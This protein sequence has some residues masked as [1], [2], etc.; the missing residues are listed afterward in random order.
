MTSAAV[1]KKLKQHFAVHG[2]LTFLLSDNEPC[3]KS[4]LFKEFA[5]TWD[6]KHATSSPNYHQSNGLTERA[7]RSAKHLLMK[8]GGDFYLDLYN[9]RNTPAAGNL[10]SPAQRLMS[11]RT[12]TRIPTTS[13]MLEPKIEKHVPLKLK[14]M[15]LQKKKHYDMNA[16][17][18]KPLQ[19][20]Q[21]VRL[22]TKRRYRERAIVMKEALRPRSYIVKTESGKEF[23]RNR[24]HFLPVQEEYHQKSNGNVPPRPQQKPESEP[25]LQEVHQ[26]P[27]LTEHSVQRTEGK[28]EPAEVQQK[29][30]VFTRA[31]R[32]VKP[33]PRFKDYI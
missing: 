18:L 6:F 19:K 25:V 20:E 9:L 1:I 22:E 5:R 26:K 29:P 8:T 11:R 14:K 10:G 12:R 3:Y 7:V 21:I 33:N 31:G 30:Q 24:R 4:D 28:N 16:K 13:M 2:I 17:P 15:R 32:M 27:V 23:K